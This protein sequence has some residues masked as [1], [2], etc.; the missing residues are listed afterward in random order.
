MRK[1]VILAL[2]LASGAGAHSAPYPGSMTNSVPS[3]SAINETGTFGLGVMLGEPMGVT[4]KFW[5]NDFVALDAGLGWSF[6]DPDGVQIHTDALFHK[7]D[8]FNSNTPDLALYAGVGLRLKFPDHG[9]TRVGIR[10]PFG[11]SFMIPEH[12][13]EL[14]AEVAPILDLTPSVRVAC[15][16]GVGIRYYFR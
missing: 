1:A 16:G 13:L 2:V 7:F 12:N 6:P 5:A 11:A 3:T 15:N 14:Y 10:V 4:A 8:P 9:D